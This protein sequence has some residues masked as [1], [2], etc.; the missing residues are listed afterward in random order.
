MNARRIGVIVLTVGLVVA[1]AGIAQA[2][3]DGGFHHGFHHAH[4]R[5]FFGLSIG[6]FWPYA[7]AYPYPYVVYP[8]AVVVPPAYVPPATQGPF[9]WYCDNPPG[10][11]PYVRSC[12]G[13]WRAVP[14]T[15]PS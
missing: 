15:P 5:F 10:Y 11:Y 6:P 13:G 7:Y 2:W 8:P 14:S 4:T 9:W 3:R 12:P 1:T